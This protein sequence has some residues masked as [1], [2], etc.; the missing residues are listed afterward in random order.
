MMVIG[1]SSNHY[2]NDG[3]RSFL[4]GFNSPWSD[5]AEPNRRQSKHVFFF[6]IHSSLPF[7]SKILH[8]AEFV[9]VVEVC[10]SGQ[11]VCWR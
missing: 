7:C 8:L 2:A 11:W 1:L 4:P 6:V 5:P 3:S 10:G 9:S